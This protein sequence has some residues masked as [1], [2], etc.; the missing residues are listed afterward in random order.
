MLTAEQDILVPPFWCHHCG[1]TGSVLTISALRLFGDQTLSA[2]IVMALNAAAV[3]HKDTGHKF[4][5]PLTKAGPAYC[6][7]SKNDK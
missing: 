4:A 6:I 3:R 1:A 7:G 2:P 5:A